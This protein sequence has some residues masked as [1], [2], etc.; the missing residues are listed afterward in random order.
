MIAIMMANTLDRP[1][2][3]PAG[4]HLLPAE[5]LRPNTEAFVAQNMLGYSFLG[6]AFTGLYGEGSGFLI[7]VIDFPKKTDAE[8]AIKE[9][10]RAV[11]AASLR[12]GGTRFQDPNNGPVTLLQKDN[13]L[14]GL[15]SPPSDDVEA[16]YASLLK[17]PS[18]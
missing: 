6:N 15:V 12:N 7:F 3:W 13:L 2:E 16:H 10:R 18:K 11:P 17:Q 1:R 14:F 9:Y 5:G 4:I 8:R